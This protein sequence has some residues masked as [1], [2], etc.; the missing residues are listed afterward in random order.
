MVDILADDSGSST[1]DYLAVLMDKKLAA[2]MAT[3]WDENWAVQLV[4]HWV[5]WVWKKVA[6]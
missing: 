1:V 2:V 3:A 4:A 5:D 6:K